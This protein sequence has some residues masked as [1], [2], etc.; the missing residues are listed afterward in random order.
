MNSPAGGFIGL[1]VL[2]YLSHSAVR[3]RF[4]IADDFTF[5]IDRGGIYDDAEVAPVPFPG[6]PLLPFTYHDPVP[7][8][9]RLH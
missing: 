8:L 1:L 2:I 6:I 7:K 5:F 3:S 9:E 4:E